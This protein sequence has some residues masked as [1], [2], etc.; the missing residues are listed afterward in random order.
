MDVGVDKG[1]CVCMNVC[2]LCAPIYMCVFMN[3]CVC[4]TFQRSTSTKVAIT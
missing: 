1:V 2:V 4:F 3:A